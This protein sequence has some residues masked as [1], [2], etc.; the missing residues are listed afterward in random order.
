[1][2]SMRNSHSL[3]LVVLLAGCSAPNEEAG[4]SDRELGGEVSQALT[5]SELL[6]AFRTSNGVSYLT[7]EGD[8]GGTISANR[9]AIGAWERF[10]ISDLNGGSLVSG[11]QVQ[12]RH[13]SAAGAS[14][15]LSADTNGG[16]VGNVLRANKTFPQAAE[17]FVIA[18]V[19]GGGVAAGDQITLRGANPFYVSAQQGGGLAGDGSVLVDRPVASTWETFT[20]VG[21]SSASLC[22]FSNA[23]CLFDQAN[24]GG[25]R[26]NVSSLNPNGTCVDLAQHGWG[27]RARSAVNTNSSNAAAFPNADCTGQPVGLSGLEP[28][29][30]LQPNSVFVF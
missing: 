2:L 9:T 6:V 24:F 13:V 16:G 3:L 17:T 15:W 28:T 8:G 21:I 18:K 7:A 19:G 10:I 20:L 26:F 30:P 25:Q 1:M 11:D 23:L 14:W 22:P 5:S 12:I 4:S 29:L 27:G